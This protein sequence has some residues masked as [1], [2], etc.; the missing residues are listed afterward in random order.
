M[1]CVSKSILSNNLLLKI[2]C[3]NVVYITFFFKKK[4][5]RKKK[6]RFFG[7]FLS[8]LIRSYFLRNKCSYKVYLNYISIVS[9]LH[10]YIYIYIMFFFFCFLFSFFTVSCLPEQQNKSGNRS[11][12]WQKGWQR[13][14]FPMSA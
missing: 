8:S 7:L 2:C 10:K 12:N 4:K 5:E 1:K 13:F 3:K 9:I 14:T 11:Q 6:S